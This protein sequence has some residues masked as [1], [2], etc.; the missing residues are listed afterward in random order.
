MVFLINNR[1]IGKIKL[2]WIL[3]LK[4]KRI[5]FPF[6]HLFMELVSENEMQWA[7]LELDKVW[8]IWRSMG[9]GGYDKTLNYHQNKERCNV[10]T[11]CKHSGFLW[12]NMVFKI[13][14][15]VKWKV[16]YGW[17][18]QTEEGVM[19]N[20]GWEIEFKDEYCRWIWHE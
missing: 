11:V 8:M 9:Y 10:V 6:H 20:R 13:Q 3:S 1:M 7:H 16:K 17:G 15:K 18:L 4:T 19:G 5:M 12:E 14:E 2:L